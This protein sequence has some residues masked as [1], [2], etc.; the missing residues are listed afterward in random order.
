M[1]FVFLFPGKTKE[2]YLEQGIADFLSRLS[3]YADC[4]IRTV[5]ERRPAKG[6]PAEKIVEEEGRSILAALPK[7]SLLVVLD[8]G[9]RAISSEDF[10]E[11]L[12]RWE[13]EGRRAVTF[14][15]GGHLGL[16]SQVLETADDKI[17]LS[18]M[19]FTHE[20]ARLILLEQLYRAFTI[21]VGSGYHK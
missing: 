14:V 21:R 8:P 11:L 3:R 4:E 16:S 7:P 6:E 5:K 2:A 19:T 13:S 10:A 17:S 9:G 1:R 18:K 20:M 12:D 15:V